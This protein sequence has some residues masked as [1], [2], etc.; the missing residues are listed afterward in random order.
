MVASVSHSLYYCMCFR[1]LTNADKAKLVRSAAASHR[2]HFPFG[3]GLVSL[4]ATSQPNKT[5]LSRK[6]FAC[7]PSHNLQ[8][9]N[10]LERLVPAQKKT[11]SVPVLFDLQTL[12]INL[13]P[14]HPPSL[15]LSFLSQTPTKP[16][17]TKLCRLDVFITSLTY[18]IECDL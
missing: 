2:S 13:Q 9:R 3:A 10:R 6:L 4:Y 8:H 16:T 17:T 18:T 11:M 5:G 15:D 7:G 12:L 14:K 1:L